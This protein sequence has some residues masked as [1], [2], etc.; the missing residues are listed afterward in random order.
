MVGRELNP[1]NHPKKDIRKVLEKLVAE[2]WTIH[3]DGHWG[4]LYCPCENRCTTIPVPSTPKNPSRDAKRIRYAAGRCPKPAD[5][6]QR[7]LTGRDRG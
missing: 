7:S 4:K 2:R 3:A 5:S 6:P 1:S